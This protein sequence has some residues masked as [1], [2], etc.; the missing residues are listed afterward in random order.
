VGIDDRV[1][2]RYEM[3]NEDA[4]LWEP[5]KGD[6]VR[7][8]TWDI[9]NRYIPPGG[10]IVDV[11]GGPGTH[12]AH[13][14]ESGYEVILVD[15]L[16]SHLDEALRRASASTDWTFGVHR[17]DASDL[18][19]PDESCDAVLLMGPLYHL[20]DADERQA[21]L[22]EARRVL[23]P[24]GVILA[25]V[26]CRHAWLLDA[27]LKDRLDESGIW[28]VF[29]RNIETGFSQDPDTAEDGAFWAYFHT[30]DELRSELRAASFGTIELLAVEGFGWLLGDLERRMHS[31]EPL[32]RAIRLTESEPSM[33][34]CSA[35]VMGVGIRP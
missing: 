5:G 2:R 30:P 19:A 25:E 35:H 7:L 29:I 31:P 26:I 6:L 17:G 12:A 34:G 32:L 13:L 23:R 27:T 33:L 24:G 22:G 9:F 15:P 11:G 8:R 10:R 21:A 4:R 16:Q 3:S 14:A 18:P 28:E 1:N 20:I